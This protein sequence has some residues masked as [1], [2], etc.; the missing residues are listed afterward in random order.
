MTHRGMRLAEDILE[1]VGSRAE[2]EVRVTSG[3][4][5]LTRFA[6]SFVHQN[7]GEEG[8][9]VSLRVAVGGRVASGATTNVDAAGLAGFVER[10]I[11]AAEV[12]PVDPDWPGLTPPVEVPATAG[13][14]QRTAQATPTDRAER[15][16]AFV[17]AGPGLDAAGY[18]ETVGHDVAFA[19]SAGHRVSDSYTRATIDGIHQTG[20]SAGSG[21]ATSSHLGGIHAAE[22]GEQAARR[23]RDSAVPFDTKPGAYEV[24]LSPECV[25]TIS[26][27]LSY[28]GFN[29]KAHAEG[30]SFARIG[31]Q[32][33]DEAVSIVDDVHDPRAFGIG[34]DTEGTP[35]RRVELVEAGIVRGLAHDRR[36]AAKAGVASTGHAVAG[37]DV[38]GPF[39]STV[40]FGGGDQTVDQLIAGVERGLYV[41]TFN[42][43]RVLDPKTMVVTGLT[44]NGTFMIENGAITDAVT[45]LRFTQSFLAALAP[46]NVAALGA[47]ARWADSEFGPGIIH[48]PSLRLRSWNFTGGSEG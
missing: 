34:F 38:Y 39:P 11:Q 12:Q 33:F 25:A 4:S 37:S 20:T 36:T 18:C 1:M 14:D 15:V 2:A 8:H 48:A 22:V 47:D 21:H 41:S 32:Q 17:D 24:V 16:K 45:N 35:R 40:F 5:A 43:C 19:N 3:V 10:T 13:F 31:E 42:Y 7:V 27:F 29:A 46:G 9:A 28:Y 6:N 30:Q 23:A 44:R 26:V